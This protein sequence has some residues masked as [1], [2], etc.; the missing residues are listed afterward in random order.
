MILL[1]A[2]VIVRPRTL[3]GV[4]ASDLSAAVSTHVEH[5]VK[6][7]TTLRPAKQ[8]KEV[9]GSGADLVLQSLQALE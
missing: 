2:V 8:P 7:R 3:L 6:C 1:R 9:S 4:S 5:A